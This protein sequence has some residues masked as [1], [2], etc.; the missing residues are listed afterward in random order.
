MR[1]T[2]DLTLET[3]MAGLSGVG[4]GD[5]A[6]D[7]GAGVDTAFEAADKP[8]THELRFARTANV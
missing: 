5:G 4:A 3:V 6:G 1:V 7:G 8:E 2:F